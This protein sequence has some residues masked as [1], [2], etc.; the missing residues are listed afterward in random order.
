MD[1]TGKGGKE[2]YKKNLK[3]NEKKRGSF[4]K[5]DHRGFFF[6]RLK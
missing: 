4:L 5:V 1:A 2:R 6:L 3:A